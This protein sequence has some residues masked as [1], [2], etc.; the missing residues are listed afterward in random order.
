MTS[1]SLGLNLASGSNFCF[2]CEQSE[3]DSSRLLVEATASS[4]TS[5]RGGPQDALNRLR[6]LSIRELGALLRAARDEAGILLD[7]GSSGTLISTCILFLLF[8]SLDEIFF[9]IW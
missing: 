9:T 3:V 1:A 5:D 2:S 7:V 8:Y 4:S 6:N